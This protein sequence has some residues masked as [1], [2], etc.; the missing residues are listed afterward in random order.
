MIS[1]G[2]IVVQTNINSFGAFAMSGSGAYSKIEGFVFLPISSMSMALPTFVSQNLGA[3]KYQRAKKGASFG[4]FSG[5][6]MAEVVGVILYIWCPVGLRLF[7]DSAEAI[8]FGTPHGRTVSF[9]FF[10][11]A[12]S[13]CAA[14]VLRGCGK[15]I[16]PMSAM[17]AFWCGVRVVYV[18]L[19]LKV[20]PEFQMIA[21]AYPLTWTL[22]SIVFVISLWKLDWEKTAF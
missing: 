20:I 16:I 22:S 12:F 13:H 18:T 10:L 17:L 4:M 3:A 1:I 11:L 8:K 19:I 14:G 7:V 9:F 15:S 6:I 5:M 21:W 2:N